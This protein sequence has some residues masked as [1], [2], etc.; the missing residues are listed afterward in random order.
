MGSYFHSATRTKFLSETRTY[1]GTKLVAVVKR[2]FSSSNYTEWIVD[3]FTKGAWLFIFIYTIKVLAL[4][5]L[6]TPKAERSNVILNFIANCLGVGQRL[7]DTRNK[8]CFAIVVWAFG[9]LI[10]RSAYQAAIYDVYR[11]SHTISPPESLDE[12]VAQKYKIYSSRL[13]NDSSSNIEVHAVT[14]PNGKYVLEMVADDNEHHSAGI[15]SYARLIHYIISRNKTDLY[16]I[17]KQPLYMQHLCAYFQ[18]HS[19]LTR[20]FDNLIAQMQSSGLLQKWS[21]NKR[22]QGLNMPLSKTEQREDLP[23]PMALY[24]FKW[25]FFIITFLHILAICV[26]LL[27]IWGIGKL[28]TLRKFKER[29]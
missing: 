27:E 3:P 17:V 10:I 24:K 14:L 19:Y 1:V 7:S 13:Y 5:L 29:F 2:I 26:F 15:V 12:I 23:Q 25:L 28:R 11:V 21:K 4:I 8:C 16:D 20:P 18:R 22:G 9:F 6:L